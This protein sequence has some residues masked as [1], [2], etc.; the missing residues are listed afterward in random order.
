VDLCTQLLIS[1]HE[2]GK[3]TFDEIRLKNFTG[4]EAQRLNDDMALG[5]H[6]GS[7]R[8][9]REFADHSICD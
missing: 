2:I 6:V 7:P 9:Y 8:R 3:E 1:L 5:F 4:L